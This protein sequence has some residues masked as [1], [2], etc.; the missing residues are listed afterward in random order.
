MTDL[1]R[2]LR[3]GPALRVTYALAGAAI[4]GALILATGGQLGV[5]AGGWFRGAFG[6]GYA[7]SQTLVYALPIAVVALGVSGALRA[8]IIT[9]GAEGQ[10]IVG[11]IAA[12]ALSLGIGPGVPAWIAL[13]LGA[14]TGAAAGAAWSLLPA[15][16]RA[17]WGMNEILATLLANYLA[18][19]LLKYLLRTDLRNPAGSATPQSAPIPEPFLLPQLPVAG[20]LHAGLLLVLL[21][22][23]VALYLGRGKRRFLLDVY[24]QRPLLAARAGLGQTRAVLGTMLVSGA[25]AG[26]AGWMQLM[27]V[28]ERLQPGVSAGIGFA[29]IAVAVL[30]RYHPLGILAAAVVYASLTT[31]ANGIQVATGSTP[32][33]VGTVSQGILLLAAALILAVPR[34]RRRTPQIRKALPDGQR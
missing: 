23:A 28:D 8:G 18:G 26:L 4:L 33:A 1:I 22:I 32:A 3:S 14:L 15:L 7:V 17:R 2:S 27:G 31:G 21:I 25:F 10:M 12:T 5:A 6:T 20:R 19:Y 34:A 13:P 24:G 30:G 11:A 16:G 9:V 29:G